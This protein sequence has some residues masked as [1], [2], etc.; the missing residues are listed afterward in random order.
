[1]QSAKYIPVT[2]H[3]KSIYLIKSDY[4]SDLTDEQCYKKELII[5]Q[6]TR[7]TK[8]LTINRVLNKTHESFSNTNFLCV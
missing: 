5:A 1:M 6:V 4:L 3:L 7:S 2:A 8:F